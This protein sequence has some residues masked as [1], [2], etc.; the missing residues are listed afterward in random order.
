MSPRVVAVIVSHHGVMDTVLAAR[1]LLAQQQP[2]DRLL[3]VDS[4]SHL[5]EQSQLARLLPSSCELDVCGANL[6]FAAAA[7]RGAR[8]AIEGGAE[9]LFFFNPDALLAADSLK[10]LLEVLKDDPGAGL[11]APLVLDRSRPR[12]VATA[13]ISVGEL[14]GR[15]RHP[16]AGRQRSE[17][18]ARL[19]EVRKVDAVAGCALLI[20][21]EVF[22]AV[23]AFD[24]STFFG[25]ED[26]ELCLRAK[27]LGWQTLLVPE[28]RCW[29]E[30]RASIGKASPDLVYYASRNHL[31]A[32]DIGA[33]LRWPLSW[34][35][36]AAIVSFNL[37]H[38]LL[39]EF[40]RGPALRAWAA[41]TVDGL[42][43]R[44]GARR[45]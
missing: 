11:A 40:A 31:R 20:R 1:S 18:A 23:G 22:A 32:L 43:G 39:G 29:H 41:G 10:L 16:E 35:R 45:A 17:L 42:T 7:N 6:G 2:L 13:G 44:F 26:I 3:V 25:F 5:E 27:N 9:W 28:A 4:G 34:F 24:E 36:R 38:A 14:T 8:A 19:V 15:M 33:P 12:L 30:G 37:A 21:A